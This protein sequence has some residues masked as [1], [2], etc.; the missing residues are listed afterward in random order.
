MHAFIKL[1]YCVNGLIIL[2]VKTLRYT[3]TAVH[4]LPN[5]HKKRKAFLRIVL[6][7]PTLM[8]SHHLKNTFLRDTFCA[9][10]QNNSSIQTSSAFFSEPLA[11]IKANWYR[12]PLS[13]WKK[14]SHGIRTSAA[15]HIWVTNP[16]TCSQQGT[17][18]WARKAQASR[19]LNLTQLCLLM[20]S[21]IISSP[22]SSDHPPVKQGLHAPT[23][24][25][26]ERIN[27][28]VLQT[29]LL[30]PSMYSHGQR[31]DRTGE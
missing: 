11:P 19:V 23:H 2:P 31:Q 28:V 21:Q 27:V 1:L 6:F 13:K 10:L 4:V 29:P 30:N 12:R 26:V 5:S 18:L 24:S 17:I 9:G 15:Q 20:L 16:S 8:P 7:A 25:S 22:C 14:L 3:I